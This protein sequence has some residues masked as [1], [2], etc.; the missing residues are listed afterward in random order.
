MTAKEKKAYDLEMAKES[1][2]SKPP[3]SPG[4]GQ[5][6]APNIKR[7]QELDNQLGDMME[8]VKPQKSKR[9]RTKRKK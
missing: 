4:Q 6:N 3:G 8:G 7:L 2:P 5:P 9:T 1:I